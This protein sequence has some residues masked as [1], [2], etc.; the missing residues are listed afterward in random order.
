MRNHVIRVYT[1]NMN[2]STYIGLI[3]GKCVVYNIQNSYQ[4]IHF[5]CQIIYFKLLF[6]Q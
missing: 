4:T 6:I 3:F 2:S 5:K 1:Q